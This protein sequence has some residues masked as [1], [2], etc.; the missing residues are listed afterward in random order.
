ML[1]DAPMVDR[2]TDRQPFFKE[3]QKCSIE[4]PCCCSHAR[5]STLICAQL[6]FE[7]MV[8]VLHRIV[9][10]THLRLMCLVDFLLDAKPACDPWLQERIPQAR[11][12]TTTCG[13]ALDSLVPSKC[14]GL[15]RLADFQVT[16]KALAIHGSEARI[17][18]TRKIVRMIFEVSC[19]FL[20]PRFLDLARLEDPQW[21]RAWHAILRL[22]RRNHG[23]KK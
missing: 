9:L 18:R 15:V 21:I 1:E 2:R 23:A 20:W 19:E 16:V 8:N 14:S 12:I 4:W 10:S 17:Q 5:R 3:S 6:S 13:D 11:N 7:S 22:L